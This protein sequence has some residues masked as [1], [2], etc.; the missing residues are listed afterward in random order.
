VI[1]APLLLAAA[2]ALPAPNMCGVCHPDVR[3]E[4][5]R[6]IHRTEGVACASCH[7]GDPAATTVAAAHGAGFRGVP[8]RRDI[9]ALCASCHSDIDQM[10]PYDLPA[11]Q[12]AL[13]L[14]SGHGRRL[15]R[16]DERVALCTDCHGVHE[17]RPRGDPRSSVFPR[18]IPA[19]CARCHADRALMSRYGRTDDPHADYLKGVHGRALLDQGNAAAPDCTRCHGS[20]G[21]SPPGVGDIDKV[22]GHCHTQAR[23]F[24]LEGP[25]KK[26]MDAAGLPECAACHGN[27]D[28]EPAGTGL[29]D[30]A[31][32]RC[33]AAGSDQLQVAQ[34]IKTLLTGAA[35][36]IEQ[37]GRL[38]ERAASIPLYVEDYRARIEEARTSL[39][40]AAPVS[41]GL[42]VGRLQE[43]TRRAAS[44]A[45]EVE[46]EINGK[47]EARRWRRVGLLLFW[48]YLLVTAA[49][50]IG[51]RR[52]AAA[53]TSS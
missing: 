36:A 40:E 22:C 45:H 30:T 52:E 41:H 20:H 8:R 28:I 29:F 42:Q 6:S 47:L 17:I 35:S 26:A 44:I 14:T 32:A 4:F 19:T 34:T 46:S 33:H 53:K 15:A 5:E 50:L 1:V 7:G 23:A 16:G 3:V 13:Y 9:P 43:L 39:L 10:R 37:A 12:H 25:H 38:V 48:F 49:I 24:F 18:N 11:D 51:F 27:H 2:V 21:A 31:C